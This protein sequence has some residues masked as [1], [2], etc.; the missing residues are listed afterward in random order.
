MDKDTLLLRLNE[1]WS[2]SLPFGWIPITSD[3][4]IPD[5]KIFDSNYLG[6]YTD[7]VKKIIKNK[8]KV[9]NLFEIREDGHFKKLNIDDCDFSYNGLEYI[10]TDENLGFVLY[11]SHESSTTIGGKELLEELQAIW[12]ESNNHFWVPLQNN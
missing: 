11:F 2:C 7:E 10:Y 6:Y 5:V 8:F 9:N 3:E 4:D 1:K 12:P